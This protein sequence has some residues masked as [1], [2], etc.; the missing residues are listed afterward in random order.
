MI[1]DIRILKHNFLQK[2]AIKRPVC[3]DREFEYEVL[4]RKGMGK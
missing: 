1:T 3:V 2:K 4:E